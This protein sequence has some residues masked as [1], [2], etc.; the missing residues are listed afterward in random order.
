MAATEKYRHQHAELV[1]IVGRIQQ[2]LDPQTLASDPK[3]VRTLLSTL[4][5]KLT[6]HL[7]MEDAALYPRM[8]KHND[9]KTRD[10]A[11][12]FIA[13]MAGVKPAVESFSRKWTEA[14][15]RANAAQFCADT[16]KLFGVLAD[17][18]QRE[19]TQLYPLADQM[20]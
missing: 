9:A 14:E 4:F 11:K 2:K 19:N 18:I 7:A 3:E 8:E 6:M 20:G 13:E 15:I 16:K 12:K 10:T 5:G 1:D 17:R